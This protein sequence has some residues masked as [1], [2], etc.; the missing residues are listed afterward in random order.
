MNPPSVFQVLLLLGFREMAQRLRG[1]S[2]ASILSLP[3]TSGSFSEGN[4][5]PTTMSSSASC[6][7]ASFTTE[8]DGFIP[9][10]PPA[11]PRPPGPRPNATAASHALC[12][13]LQTMPALT[14]CGAMAPGPPLA[15]AKGHERSCESAA[16]ASGGGGG[17]TLE[18]GGRH[19]CAAKRPVRSPAVEEVVGLAGLARDVAWVSVDLPD[20]P[21]SLTLELPHTPTSAVS[22]LSTRRSSSVTVAPGSHVVR[23]EG[24]G[25]LRLGAL[26]AAEEGQ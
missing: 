14:A 4:P 22:G 13:D 8:D 21:T 7:K 6:P 23:P 19:F 9:Q 18:A 26:H 24:E 20:S 25:T 15:E 3:F 12:G 16:G 10:S 11:P 5:E 2:I 1:R 17:A